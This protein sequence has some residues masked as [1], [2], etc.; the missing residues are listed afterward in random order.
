MAKRHDEDTNQEDQQQEDDWHDRVQNSLG[1][2]GTMGHEAHQDELART[3][4]EWNQ[5]YEHDETET[6]LESWLHNAQQPPT[7]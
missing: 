1:M 3:T 4:L 2:W 5:D 7:L 6:E